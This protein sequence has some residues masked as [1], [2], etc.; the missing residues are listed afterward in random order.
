M[1]AIRACGVVE[2]KGYAPVCQDTL[3]FVYT[4]WI[5]PQGRG[6][7][8]ACRRSCAFFFEGIVGKIA[9]LRRIEHY[10]KVSEKHL[11]VLIVARSCP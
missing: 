7:K 5:L 11:K 8:G 4:G 6:L 3:S 2:T 10:E 1:V 9:D